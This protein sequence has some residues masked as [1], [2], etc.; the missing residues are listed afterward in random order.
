MSDVADVNE[1]LSQALEFLLMKREEYRYYS[2]QADAI[3]AEM[4]EAQDR[5]VDIM[6][7]AGLTKAGTADVTMSLSY[8]EVPNVDVE[9]WDELRFW[10]VKNGYQAILPRSI[11]AAPWRELK[12]MGVDVPFTSAF[13][14]LKV[15][16]KKS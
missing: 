13:R 11:N 10:A 3:K 9:H 14:K 7:E 8:E 15:S 1:T 12:A 6:N 4:V 5:C 16:F 2:R